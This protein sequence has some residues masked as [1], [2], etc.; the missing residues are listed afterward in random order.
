MSWAWVDAARPIPHD[1]GG[2][3]ADEYCRQR[4]TDSVRPEETIAA[5]PGRQKRR[6][7]RIRVGRALTRSSSQ[8]RCGC[9]RARASYRFA[10]SLAG[11][12]EPRNQWKLRN[13]SPR[14]FVR[15]A[16]R[17]TTTRV[18]LQRSKS[19]S[20]TPY[21]D[22]EHGGRCIDSRDIAMRESASG[23]SDWTSRASRPAARSRRAARP[24]HPSELGI[25]AM[26]G[27]AH[28]GTAWAMRPGH[29]TPFLRN[30]LTWAGPISRTR[31]Q[32]RADDPCQHRG[33]SDGDARQAAS[34]AP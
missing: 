24:P 8:L 28:L 9:E 26:A 11:P 16:P 12:R 29:R 2:V 27:V 33:P 7:E 31:P 18:D 6:C 4:S 23:T 22:E 15:T 25:P 21:V 32:I 34:S 14:A 20:R 13:G 1:E 10:R 5:L 30:F 17:V 3:S 19:P